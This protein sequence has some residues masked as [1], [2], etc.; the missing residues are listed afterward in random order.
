MKH[1]LMTLLVGW[2]FWV[3]VPP[4]SYIT[5]GEQ[6][7]TVAQFPPLYGPYNTWNDCA[8]QFLM[9]VKGFPKAGE[10]SSGCY[11]NDVSVDTPDQF[12]CD[13]SSLRPGKP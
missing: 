3:V 10:I 7:N 6:V 8:C 1:L 4:G 5:T 11:G 2:Y 9:M 13:L 12:S